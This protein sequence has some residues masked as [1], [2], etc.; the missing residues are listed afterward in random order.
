MTSTPILRYA[1]TSTLPARSQACLQQCTFY[2]LSST[3][4][5]A[6]SL[7]MSITSTTVHS[8]PISIMPTSVHSLQITKCIQTI[9]LPA[10][11]NH[12][13]HRALS[14]HFNHAYTATVANY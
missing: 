6:H 11:N 10:N 2:E 14:T 4:T 13:Y 9:A 8:L 1:Y 5:P 12:A 7:Q 3:S